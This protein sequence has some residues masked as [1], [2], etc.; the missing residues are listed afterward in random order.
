MSQNSVVSTTYSNMTYDISIPQT[1]YICANGNQTLAFTAP[2]RHDPTWTTESWLNVELGDILQGNLTLEGVPIGSDTGDMRPNATNHIL[3]SFNTS[4]D[5]PGT[6]DRVALAMTT[7]LRQLS[8]LS[9]NGEAGTLETV[10]HVKWVWLCLPATLVVSGAICLSITIRESNKHGSHVWKTS[11]M[12]LLFHGLDTTIEGAAS[13]GRVSEMDAL[14][15]Q[16]PVNLAQN[17]EDGLRQRRKI[18]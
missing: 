18:A 12:A 14:A 8:N 6:M 5:I 4:T 7:H 3:Y 13:L 2:A 9:Q 11:A 15:K 17:A 1:S 16:T 10:I